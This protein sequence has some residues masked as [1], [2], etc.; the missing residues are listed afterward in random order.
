[1]DDVL[2]YLIIA[3]IIVGFAFGFALQLQEVLL[4]RKNNE[5]VHKRLLYGYY[6]RCVAYVGFLTAYL[7]NVLV[8]A[9]ILQNAYFTDS[10]TSL[11]SSLFLIVLLFT[12]FVM[13]QKKSMR[14]QKEKL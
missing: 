13:R 1:M 2:G 14:M 4:I 7:L 10:N 6:V 12:H 5:T 3:I 11:W 9:G 8:A